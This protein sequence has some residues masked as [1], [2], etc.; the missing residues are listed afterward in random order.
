M[1]FSVD[2]TE[3]LRMLARYTPAEVAKI[4]EESAAAGAGAGGQVMRG[5]APVGR[6][7]LSTRY[8]REGLTHGY[9]RSTV[10]S[11]AIRHPH[12][13]QA[14]GQVIGPMG[15]HAY[16]RG[17]IEKRTG[18]GARAASLARLA[19]ARASE[20]VLERYARAR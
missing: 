9:F 7:K 19:I 10:R 5:Q 13:G 20:A 1:T 12:L 2:R 6:A 18:W 11:A 17:W 3:E 8:I 15:V 4:L 14:A 16:P